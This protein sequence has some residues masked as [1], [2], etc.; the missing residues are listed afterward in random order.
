MPYLDSLD[1]GNKAVQLVGSRQ[2]ASVSEDSVV[3]IEIS[4][5][6]DKALEPELR[7]NRWRFATKTVALRAINPGT[8]LLTPQLYNSGTTYTAGAIV[9]DTNGQWWTSTLE[10]N[11]NNTPGGNNNAWD[12]YFGPRTVSPY[13]TTGTTGYYAGELVYVAGSTAGSYQIYE[14]LQQ[15]NTIVPNVGTTWSATTTYFGGQIVLYSGRYYRS[16]S[17]FNL[18]VTPFD[19]SVYYP[20]NAATAYTSTNTV[21]GSDGFVYTATGSTTGN[22]P[23]TDGGVHWTQGIYNAWIK[24][25]ATQVVSATSWNPV[26]CYMTNLVFAY[27]I[28]SGPALQ[29]YTRNAFY[30]PA[31]YLQVAPQDPKAGAT[32]ILGAPSGSMISDWVFQDQC[33]TS[34]NPGPLVLRFVAK[35]TRVASMDPMFCHGL[36]CQ[37]ALAVVEKLTQS[38]EKLKAIASEYALVMREARLCNAIEISYEE[39]PE[40][41]YVT[42]RL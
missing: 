36:A 35:V 25:P 15:N 30:L 34:A 22:D 42:C 13:D 12:A 17:E 1:I 37:V 11:I 6:Y 3:N 4:F 28:G 32:S 41:D 33:I 27:P 39:P 14:S 2:I 29:S 26:F 16:T 24:L 31:G 20:W 38:T 10:T 8:M 5:A 19:G 40:D 7:R 23:T 9:A 21:T 18:N